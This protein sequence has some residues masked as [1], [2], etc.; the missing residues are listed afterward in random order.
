WAQGRFAR[1]GS[2]GTG[3]IAVAWAGCHQGSRDPRPGWQGQSAAMPRIGGTGASLHSAPA[4]P[5]SPAG[6]SH[7]G[8]SLQYPFCPD[9]DWLGRRR[10][11]LEDRLSG[12]GYDEFVECRAAAGRNVDPGNQPPYT[13]AVSRSINRIPLSS[14][15]HNNDTV[16]SKFYLD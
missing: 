16:P 5:T 11:S 8:S 1:H 9:Y 12:L 2:D 13:S 14:N 4:T 10:V 15:N 3:L 7:P 6:P